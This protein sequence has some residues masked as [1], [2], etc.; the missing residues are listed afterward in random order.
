MRFGLKALSLTIV[1]L[2]FSLTGSAM[3]KPSEHP[4]EIVPGS[5]HITPSTTQAGAHADLTTTFD[6]AHNALGETYNDLRTTVVNLPPGFLGSN[7]AVPTCTD[8]QLSS[9]PAQCPLDTQVGEITLDLAPYGPFDPPLRDSFP[10]YNMEA[11]SG[12]AATLGFHAFFI[13]QI[14]P[15]TVRPSDEGLT[16]TSPSIIDFAEPHDISLTIWGVPASP[17]HNAQRGLECS[18]IAGEAFSEPPCSGGGKEVNIPIEPFL[19]NPTSCSKAPLTATL[20][21]NSWQEPEHFAEASTEIA[22]MTGCE[23]LPFSPTFEVQPTTKSAESPSGLS[24]SI[25]VPQTAENPDTLTS[26]HLQDTKV[27]LPEGMTIN[28]SAGSGLGACTPQQLQAETAQSPPGAGCPPEA[29]IGSIEIETP[30]L[31]EKLFGAV[32]I[33]TPFDNPFNSL[34]SL[35]IVAKAPERGVIVK[36]AGKIEPN[37]IT[38]RLVTTFDNTPQAPFSKFTLKFRSGATAPL[39][40]PPACGS[41]DAQAELTPY[42]TPL[43]PQLVSSTPFELTD[44]AHEGPCPI[45][46][47]TA[48]QTADRLGRAE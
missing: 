46:R 40:S 26:S 19:Y 27:T 25:L 35:Y 44:G 33:A 5:F 37:P 18:A 2:S 8:A 11:N 6:F 14:L 13:T 39:V 42:S 48:V 1:L 47:H 7:T 4:F 28:P 20:A 43:E 36:V 34:L 38:G 9:E 30:L 45:R 23:R 24:A 15:V 32:Y 29:K 10:V 12:V 3:A 21:S 22:P 31:S 17:I 41:Y 16:V